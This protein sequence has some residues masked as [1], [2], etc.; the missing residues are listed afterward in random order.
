M[1]TV[2]LPDIARLFTLAAIWGLSFLFMRIISPVFGAFLAADLRLL[3]AGIALVGYFFVTGYSLDWKKHWRHYL[4]IGAINCSLPFVFFCFAAQHI[5]ASYSAIFNATSP[6]FGAIFSAIWLG[7]GFSWRTLAGLV[8]GLSGVAL[9]AK[10]GPVETGY[11]F[12]LSLA[13]CMGASISYGLGGVYVRKFASQIPAPSIAAGSQMLAGLLL[14]PTLPLGPSPG[15]ITPVI[16]GSTLALGLL[17][18]AVAYLIY[19]RLIADI[20]PAKALTVTFLVPIFGMIWSSLFLG[21]TITAGM[22][23]GSILVLL[24][25][26]GVS[27]G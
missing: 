23:A 8:C 22:V 13:S 3:I 17:C 26:F 27:R 10:V 12:W 24:G 25:T 14:L 5:P 6:I 15:E 11:W 1:R 7:T 2:T 21:E 19:Y 9:V 4:A 18:S 16:I 20:G